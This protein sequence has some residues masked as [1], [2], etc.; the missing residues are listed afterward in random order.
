MAGSFRKVRQ[1]K[2]AGFFAEVVAPGHNRENG[3]V[4]F[5]RNFLLL[6]ANCSLPFFG[7]YLVGQNAIGTFAPRLSFAK[8]Q[9]RV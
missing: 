5:T 7:S 9:K 1:T 2:I 4:L 3:P 6:G 8:C